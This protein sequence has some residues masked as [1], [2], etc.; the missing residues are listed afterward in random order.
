MLVLQRRE[1][2]T[3]VIGENIRITV[4]EVGNDTVR[5]AID[6]PQDVRVFREE[7]L[8]AAETNRESAVDSR[9]DLEKFLHAFER[10]DT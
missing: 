10:K 8:K 4:L 5:L 1:K 7:L 9:A 6:A 3:I 2:E